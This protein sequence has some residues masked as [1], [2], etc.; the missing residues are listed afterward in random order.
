[1]VTWQGSN[2]VRVAERYEIVESGIGVERETSETARWYNPW[3]F[4]KVVV[5]RGTAERA[6]WYNPWQFPKVVNELIS[7]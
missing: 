4:P 3:Q 1:M 7:S 2:E 6:R 5:E